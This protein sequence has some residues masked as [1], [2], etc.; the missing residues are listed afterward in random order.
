MSLDLSWQAS[1]WVT[2]NLTADA[3][4]IRPCARSSQIVTALGINDVRADKSS[5][6]IITALDALI[7]ADIAAGYRPIITT[8]L[9][10][11]ETAPRI[12]VINAVNVWI[13][14]QT[15]AIVIN[16]ALLPHTLDPA[17]LT[18][19]QDGLHPTIALSAE[20]GAFAVAYLT[21]GLA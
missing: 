3:R 9:P 8:I 7:T 11:S 10:S 18:Y 14:A 13:L 21:P 20:M 6:T 1:L 4:S 5:A 15:R 16:W 17:N 19:Y 12:A 2:N